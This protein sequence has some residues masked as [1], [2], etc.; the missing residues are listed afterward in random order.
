MNIPTLTTSRLTLR[1][2]TEA[3]VEPL[4][5]IL[6]EDGILRYFP[7]PDPPD[8]ARVERLITGQLRHWEEHGLGWWAVELRATGELLGWNGLQYLPDT[9]EVEVGYLLSRRHWGQGLATEGAQASLRFGLETLRLGSIV[10]IVHP[11]NIASQQVLTKAG[12]TFIN[13][14][15]YFGMHV[16]RYVTTADRLGAYTIST[17]PGKLDAGFIQD[18]LANSSYWAQNRSLAVTQKALANSLCFGVY[19]ETE[20]VGLARVVTDYATFA[21]VCD[22]F[23]AEAHRRRGLG[24]WLIECVVT[25]PDLRGLKQI[26]LATRDAHELYRRYGGFD[27][28]PAPEKW[29]IRCKQ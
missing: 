14:A 13:E 7:R 23:I 16:C 10:G 2:F 27:G 15:D 12:L 1:P 29:M 3:D 11:E 8:R 19:S 20:Q 17:D 22:V 25:H 24:K 21:W 28:L 6:N 26:L 4:H 9:E 5:G 18:F